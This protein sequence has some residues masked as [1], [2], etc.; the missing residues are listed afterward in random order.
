MKKGGSVLCRAQSVKYAWM[1][2]HSDQCTVSAMC[3][4]LEVARSGYSE[5]LKRPPSPPA[6]AEQVLSERIVPQV[7]AYRHVYGTRRLTVCFAQEGQP[8]SRRR[9]GR[10]MAAQA[11]Q[12][13]TRRT[14]T[15]TTDSSHGQA[16]AP[17]VLQRSATSISRIRPMLVTSPTSGPLRAG[18]ISR[19]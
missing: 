15:P 9:I 5:W 2:L 4:A 6:Q 19:W 12:V 11:L 13:K 8:G 1:Q 7:A 16:V 3:R 18:G 14:F 17:N 10:L